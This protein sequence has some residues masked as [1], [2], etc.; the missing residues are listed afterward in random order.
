MTKFVLSTL[1]ALSLNSAATAG[2]PWLDRATGQSPEY[3]MGLVVGG[4]ASN[5]VGGM[6]RSEL[7]QAWS[8][9]IRGGALDHVTASDEYKSGL[10]QF[11]GAPDPDAAESSLQQAMGSCGL[12]RTGHQITGW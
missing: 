10:A 7:W 4:L 6:S 1:L 2:L 3:C 11:Q 9:L 5:K 8:Y 12:G